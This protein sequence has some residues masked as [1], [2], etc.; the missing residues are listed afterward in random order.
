MAIIVWKKLNNPP[1]AVIAISIIDGLGYVPT[2]RKSFAEPWSETLKFWTLMAI[3][4]VLTIISSAH[5]NFLTVTYLA[6]LTAADIIILIICFS[7]RKILQKN[8]SHVK[9]KQP[10]N[11]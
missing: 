1:L 8:N 6:T 2:F 11:S 7:R 10:F 4:N 9:K 5:Y 3:A